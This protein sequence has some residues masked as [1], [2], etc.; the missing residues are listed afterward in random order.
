MKF[1]HDINSL[2]CTCKPELFLACDECQPPVHDVV[3]GDCW[4]CN[5]KRMIPCTRYQAEESPIP[6]IVVHREMGKDN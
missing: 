5:G 1:L 3:L 4:K 6:V 2:D